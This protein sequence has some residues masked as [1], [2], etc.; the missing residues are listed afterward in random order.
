MVKTQ[1]QLPDHL[2]REA[3]RI[4][5]E[6]EMSF[7][8]VV[9]RSLERTMPGYPPKSSATWHPPEPLDLGPVLAPVEDWR[10]LANEQPPEISTP[11][12]R[13]RSKPSSRQ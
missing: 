10:L 7:A 2:F 5:A 3:K 13:R 4:A 9:R 12:R 11:S 1:I 8:E 6:Y